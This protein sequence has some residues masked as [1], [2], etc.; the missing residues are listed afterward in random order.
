MPARTF[1]ALNFFNDRIVFDDY[2]A[3]ASVTAA[4]A[5]AAGLRGVVREDGCDFF[6]SAA[7]DGH[8]AIGAPASSNACTI[9]TG[10]CDG[11]RQ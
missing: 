8:I 6:D 1:T 4:N 11:R 2:I 3:V 9:N 5:R 7:A 10:G